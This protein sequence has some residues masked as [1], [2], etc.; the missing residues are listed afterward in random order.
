M[1]ALYGLFAYL[2]HRPY[3]LY[4]V[5][6]G[7]AL[8]VFTLSANMLPNKWT[9]KKRAQLAWDEAVADMCAFLE[10]RPDFPV[11]AQYA[12][13]VVLDRMI[14]VLREG[15]AKDSAKAY[16]VMK[17]EL[18][19]LNSAVKVS[20]QEYDEVVAIKPLFLVCNYQDEI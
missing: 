18:K 10:A 6:G 8:F 1:L 9:S 19:A 3:A 2:T 16:S 7:A 12:H 4:F 11:P 20:Q 15:K 5:L 14:R 13:P 17:K